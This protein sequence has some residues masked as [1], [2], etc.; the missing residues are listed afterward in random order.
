MASN[1]PAQTLTTLTYTNNST[2]A[3]STYTFVVPW[4][5]NSLTLQAWGGGGGG[6]GGD[7][8]FGGSGG[9]GAYASMSISVSPGSSLIINVA[10]GGVNGLISSGGGGGIGGF[11]LGNGGNGGASGTQN[12]SGEGGGGGGS[13]SIYLNNLPLLIAAGG[14]GGGGGGMMDAGGNGGGGGNFGLSTVTASGGIV[15]MGNGMNGTNGLSFGVPVAYNGGFDGGGGGGGGAGLIGGSGG[16]Y[17]T[18]GCDCGGGGGGGGTSF[19]SIVINGNG[20]LPGNNSGLT[21]CSVCAL[22]GSGGLYNGPPATQGG[23]GLVLISYL[24]STYPFQGTLSATGALT[25]LNNSVTMLAAP[26][27]S[28]GASNYLWSGPFLFGSVNTP[29]AIAGQPGIYTLSV[30][31][32]S[33]PTTATVAISQNTL[34]PNLSANVSNSLNCIVT[35]ATLVGNSNTSGVSFLWQPQNANSNSV[36]VLAA[37][38]YSLSVTD[39]VNGCTTNTLVAVLQNTTVPNIVANVSNSLN[40]IQSTANLS[41]SSITAGVNY[42]WFSAVSG[43]IS[44]SAITVNL[45]GSYSLSV[46]N[47]M[48]GCSS[49]TVLTVTQNTTLP[50]VWASASNS[51]NCQFNAATLNAISTDT[52]VSFAWNG[53]ALNNVANPAIVNLPGTYSVSATNTLT[54]CQSYT[55]ISVLQNTTAPTNSITVSNPLSC[56]RP[57]ALLMGLLDVATSSFTWFP[58]NLTTQ[59]VLISAGGTYSLIATNR[60]NGCTNTATVTVPAAQI[61]SSN[62]AILS[63][64]KC[65]GDSTG[66]LEINTISGGQSPF[67]IRVLNNNNTIHTIASLPFSILNLIAGTYSIIITDAN[68]CSQT[69]LININQPPKLISTIKGSHTACEGEAISLNALANGGTW[70]YAY[71]W[72]NH[73]GNGSVL[74][75]I[76]TS[77]TVYSV[78]VTDYSGCTS[79]AQHIVTV[80]PKPKATLLN[81][82]VVG[83]SPICISFSLSTLKTDG[84]LFNWS[85]SSQTSI[86]PEIQSNGTFPTIC[87]EYGANYNANIKVTSPE[88]CSLD[89]AYPRLI[90]VHP[91]PKADFTFE[92]KELTIIEPAVKLINLSSNAYIYEW[93]ANNALISYQTNAPYTFASP[94][95]FNI[96]LVAS[97]LMCADTISKYV[98]IED[99]FSIYIPDTF[100]PNGDGLNDNFYPVISGYDGKAYQFSVFDRW[101]E[102]IYHSTDFRETQW[103]G[104]FKNEPCKEDVY[105][106]KL[107]TEIRNS[108]TIEKTGCVKL[109]R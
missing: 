4:C 64:V 21:S 82:P 61:F 3:G 40:C 32:G 55:V 105:A 15:G 38:S 17:S 6:G 68:G 103:N 10:D 23:K 19:G 16:G 108:K 31:Q 100:T 28:I 24:Q 72:S 18:M 70:P 59:N 39:P 11:G 96:T 107:R 75:T 94:G 35:S 54:G 22:G 67:T 84:Y 92:P 87:F 51:L 13:S 8:S 73:P 60:S 101:G 1:L 42:N 106:W 2:P 95:I 45:P 7:A 36:T 79:I 57:T 80:K 27:A 56:Q 88:G 9:G 65:F 109:I 66:A 34:S 47:P 63:H 26:T 85:F 90:S 98:T 48:N 83:C 29:T 44:Q 86:A 77:G 81:S 30:L 104:Y 97:N 93:Y 12:L 99:V 46:V 89:L 37:G 5:V 33:C 41:G 78:N 91:K 49:T 69:L 71:A 25:C 52:A 20:S 50:T 76:A 102:L 74:N 58:Q 62:S 53:G 43:P 14:G